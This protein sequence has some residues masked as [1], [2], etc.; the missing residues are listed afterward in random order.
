MEGLVGIPSFSLPFSGGLAIQ[1]L[2]PSN[3][4]RLLVTGGTGFLGRVLVRQAL[5]CGMEVAVLTRSVPCVGDQRIRWIPG[6]LSSPDWTAVQ[7][8]QPEVCVHAAWIA[9][10][11][12]YLQSP[13]NDGWADSSFHFL[14]R[15]SEMGLKR[16]V[17]L[18]TCI[19]YEMTG[20]PFREGITAI[21]PTSSYAI[22]KDNLHTRLAAE[23]ATR[24]TSLAWPRIFYPYGPGEH[25]ARLASSLIHRLRAGEPIRLKTPDSI[26]DYIH[27]EDVGR[28]LI[29]LVQSSFQGAVNIG[30]GTGIQIA[31]FAGILAD[32]LGRPE[33]VER[34]VAVPDPLDRVVADNR[35]LLSLG[36]QAEVKLVEGLHDMVERM[37]K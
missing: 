21:R 24:E 14:T 17:A 3:L 4:M 19:E 32:L 6:T 15:L 25:P 27:V 33:L 30:S 22:A 1:T 10:P 23:L 9:T 11:G 12:V 16:A 34:E 29:C 31:E 26:K 20:H 2:L 13:E 5:G 18:G 35:L 37:T 28:A 8:W 36:W 7:E